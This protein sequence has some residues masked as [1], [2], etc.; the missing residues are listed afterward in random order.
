[1]TNH[2]TTGIMT[3]NRKR[4]KVRYRKKRSGSRRSRKGKDYMFTVNCLT[5]S[6]NEHSSYALLQHS[7]QG[8]CVVRSYEI[9]KRQNT[10]ISDIGIP[11]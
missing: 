9:G 10:V 4:V 7:E 8:Y 3:S 6:Y 5:K 1:M 2:Y 11:R